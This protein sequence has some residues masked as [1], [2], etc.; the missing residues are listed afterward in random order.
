M[1]PRELAIRSQSGANTAPDCVT[2]RRGLAYLFKGRTPFSKK[3][4][5][6]FS[7]LD[8]KEGN[9]M[10]DKNVRNVLLIALAVIGGLAVLGLLGTLLMM[11]G[12]MSGMANCCGGAAGFW[13]AGLLLVALI[14]VAAV[15]LVRRKS[16]R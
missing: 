15:L 5:L 12:M 1:D 7:P 13:V 4:L 14:V 10:V 3:I 11:G 8:C 2:W 6:I 9:N 16:P